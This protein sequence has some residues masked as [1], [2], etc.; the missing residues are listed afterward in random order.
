MEYLHKIEKL[1]GG[2]D[3][4]WNIPEQK[5]GDINII[6][7]NLQNFRTSVKVAEFLTANYPLKTINVVLPDALKNK[8]PPLPNLV[9]LSSTDSGSLANATEITNTLDSADFNLLVGDFSK[10]SITTQAITEAC[11]RTTKP[12][13]VTRDT[14]DLLTEGKTERILM[15]ENLILMGSMAQLQKIFRAVY[16]PKVLLLTQSLMQVA[17]AIHKFTLSY[18]VSIITL[19]DGQIIIAKNGELNV[20]PISSTKYSPLSMW[21]GELAARI[22]ALNLYNPNNFNK[23]T[24]V[25]LFT[26]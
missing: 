5:Q 19:H 11:Q 7:G 2:E 8:L 4:L 22:M 20:V 26:R 25:A 12:T 24:T 13:I 1:E 9:F 17:E 10:N 15:N 6:G 3:L 21:D 14:V 18:P 16:Y 23:A